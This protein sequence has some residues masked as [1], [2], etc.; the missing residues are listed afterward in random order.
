MIKTFSRLTAYRINKAYDPELYDGRREHII[1][2]H[3]LDL[4]DPPCLPE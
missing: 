2:K 3:N 1:R 4:R